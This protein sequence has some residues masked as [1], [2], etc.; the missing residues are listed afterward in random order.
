M[1]ANLAEVPPA[2]ITLS[3]VGIPLGSGALEGVDAI[4]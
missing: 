2:H 3:V 1:A 4:Y